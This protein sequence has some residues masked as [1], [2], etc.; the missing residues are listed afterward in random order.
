MTGDP[1]GG[2]GSGDPGGGS[3]PDAPEGGDGS[4]GRGADDRPAGTMADVV[5]EVFA[6]L[7]EGEEGIDLLRTL[8]P[9]YRTVS[10]D[11]EAVVDARVETV[12]S[13][14]GEDPES[15]LVLACGV[16]DLLERLAGEYPRVLGVEPE[17]RIA[18]IASRRAGVPVVVGDPTDP[19]LRGRFDAVVGLGY[20]TVRP[21]AED[22]PDRLFETVRNL[23]SPGGTLVLDAPEEPR[24][25][26]GGPLSGEVGGYRVER[27]VA[28]GDVTGDRAEMG[29]DYELERTA[30]GEVTGTVQHATVRL[31]DP[32][33][34]AD[35]LSAA[36]F[37]DVRV[38]RNE[39]EP[40]GLVAAGRRGD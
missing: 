36:G 9:I 38:N 33:D 4:G 30:D 29:V 3:A 21:T 15:V 6:A 7:R 19:P 32:D 40:G 10:R 2:D 14:L 28:A 23:L 16:G 27:S 17:P 11:G 34:L 18:G 12:R 1:G 20:P 26:L 8:D 22:D 13:A 24:A 35:A 37:V 5:A 31:F 25:V 39:D